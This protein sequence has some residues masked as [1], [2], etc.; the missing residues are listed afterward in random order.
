M[1]YHCEIILPSDVDD[2]ES[3]IASIMEPFNENGDPTDDDYYPSNSFWDWYVIGGRFAGAKQ[4]AKYD[5][6]KVEEFHKWCDDE[7]VTVSGLQCGKQTLEPSSQIQKVDAKWNEMFPSGDRITACPIFSHSNDQYGRVASGTIDG[8]IG[9]L[10]EAMRQSCSRVIIASRSMG[11]DSF[12]YTG[13]YR[14]EHMICDSTWNGVNFMNTDWD[15]RV[16]TAIDSFKKRLE[17][18]KEAHRERVT[19]TDD[20]IAVTVD[21]HS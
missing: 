12:E 20:W 4:M 18:W 9:P 7:G 11:L 15:G 8:D 14:A 10:S 13:P 2:V 1:H 16:E 3:A 5:A 6:E 17:N 21:Y 19:P